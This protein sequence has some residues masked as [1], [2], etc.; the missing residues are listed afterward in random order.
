M[1][2][3]FPAVQWLRFR[4]PVQG[5]QVQSLVRELRSHMLS[6]VV[7]KKKKKSN[8]SHLHLFF[9]GKKGDKENKG[10]QAN[11]LHRMVTN[12]WWVCV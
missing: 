11:L 1:I 4:L 3:A 2:G 6:D 12:R 7:G 8:D 5:V 9:K 10:K